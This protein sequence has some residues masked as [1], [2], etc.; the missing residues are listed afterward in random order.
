MKNER[1]KNEK[2]LYPHQRA[3]PAGEFVIVEFILGF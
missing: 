2:S 3:R 1:V